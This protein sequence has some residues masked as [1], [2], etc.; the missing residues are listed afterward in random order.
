MPAR[1]LRI[2]GTR[3]LWYG[4]VCGAEQPVAC[5]I[6]EQPVAHRVKVT[7]LPCQSRS[8][9]GVRTHRGL[10]GSLANCCVITSFKVRFEQAVRCNSS[11]SGTK[12]PGFFNK[13]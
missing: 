13:I 3:S 10:S 12:A 2:Q 8:C 9:S 6:T 5:S 7:P 11:V 1:A 4:A